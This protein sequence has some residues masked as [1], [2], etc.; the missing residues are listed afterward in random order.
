MS[1]IHIVGCHLSK[2]SYFRWR[3]DMSG[4]LTRHANSHTISNL[5]LRVRCDNIL[6]QPRL[7]QVTSTIWW[8]SLLQDIFSK[9]QEN[10]LNTRR[11]PT[12]R[13]GWLL[14]ILPQVLTKRDWIVGGQGFF[15]K[16]LDLELFIGRSA[17]GNE[18]SM[19]FLL[20]FL[21]HWRG[22]SIVAATH[23]QSVATHRYLSI[24]LIV[25]IT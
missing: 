17:R 18:M 11:E 12:L 1:S 7:R 6:R 15:L 14:L 22:E 16:R 19:I 21:N 24:K 13:I 23:I 8:K 5:A 2:G 9:S 25:A 10:L 3:E 4:K 20:T